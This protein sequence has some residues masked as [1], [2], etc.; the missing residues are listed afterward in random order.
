MGRGLAFDDEIATQQPMRIPPDAHPTHFRKQ[1][2][3]QAVG[4]FGKAEVRAEQSG[5]PRG[6]GG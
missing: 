2:R 4:N 5:E 6:H 3:S 1:K